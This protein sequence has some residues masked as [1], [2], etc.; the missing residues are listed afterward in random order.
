MVKKMPRQMEFQKVQVVVR[1]VRRMQLKMINVS[2][3]S[4]TFV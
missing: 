2:C 4:I 1:K 3:S